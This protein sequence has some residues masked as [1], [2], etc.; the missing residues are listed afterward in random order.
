[1]GGRLR[2]VRLY[3]NPIFNTKKGQEKIFF[4]LNVL[5]IIVFLEEITQ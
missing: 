1:M 2:E 5:L 3:K 4:A